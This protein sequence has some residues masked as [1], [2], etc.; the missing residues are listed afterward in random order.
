MLRDWCQRKAD[1][2]RPPA[3]PVPGSAD[4]I[5]DGMETAELRCRLD[6]APEAGETVTLCNAQR[7]P[8]A[9]LRV[10]E[11]LELPQ[12]GA[13]WAALA[14]EPWSDADLLRDGVMRAE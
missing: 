12:P 13:E 1:P 2:R 14:V 8:I 7:W 6:H 10:A 9:C 11:V 3:R 4:P 5:P